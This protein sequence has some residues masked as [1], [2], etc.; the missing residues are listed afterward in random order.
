MTAVRPARRDHPAEPALARIPFPLVDEFSRQHQ[1]P[2]EPIAVH[3]EIR[4]PGQPEPA[5][6]RAAFRAA[7]CRH[8]R[9]LVREAPGRWYRRR[10]EWELTDAPDLEPVGFPPAGPDALARARAV[11]LAEAPPLSLAPPI[12]LEV[13]RSSPTAAGCVLLCTIHHTALDGPAFLRVLA[14]TAEL[15]GG[16]GEPA[17]P[18]PNH[19]ARPAPGRPAG[20]TLDPGPPLARSAR[21][22]PAPAAHP[23]RRVG[24]GVLLGEL[25]VRPR[26]PGADHTVN[27]RLLVATCLMIARWN[28]L[29]DAPT[30]PIRIT[31]PIDDRPRGVEMPIGNGTRLVEVRFGPREY[32]GEPGPDQIAE[33]LRRTARRTA[34]LKAIRR[35]PLGRGAALLTAPV[36]PVGLR[37]AL[38]RGLGR[39]IGPW[40][41][42]TLLSNLGR[43]PYPLDFGDAGRADAVWVSAPTRMPR[44]LTL[45]TTGT[46]DRL[47]VALRWSRALLDDEAGRRLYGFFAESLA[48]VS[49]VPPTEGGAP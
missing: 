32:A 38:T 25:P 22:A 7:L 48:A 27:D 26:P 31:M 46:G 11:A 29:H 23:G 8:A 20:P 45:T 5:R 40:T 28:R 47:H 18:P 49:A 16:A 21:V 44:G 35:P 39:A 43:I 13:I 30:R 10:Y 37:A 2:G 15:Y 3:M 4:L 41:S 34:E 33:L 17:D 42:S 9:A 6:L 36:L 24:N 19:S 12:R 1:R 14:S